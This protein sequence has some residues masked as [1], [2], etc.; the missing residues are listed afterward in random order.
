MLNFV[1]FPACKMLEEK[2]CFKLQRVLFVFHNVQHA[3]LQGMQGC[4]LHLVKHLVTIHNS[5]H[6]HSS[7]LSQDHDCSRMVQT[8]YTARK[9]LTSN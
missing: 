6:R 8:V 7:H 9:K 1:L 4:C 5:R 3:Q 2:N